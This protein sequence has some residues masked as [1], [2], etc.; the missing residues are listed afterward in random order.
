[1][2]PE[3]KTALL[4]WL[5]NKGLL[6]Q[7]YEA[8][9]ITPTVIKS[10]EARLKVHALIMQ[11]FKKSEACRRVANMLGCHPKHVYTYLR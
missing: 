6:S 3:K 1:M 9:I 4:I 2:S 7:L 8:G 5:K 11:G 10:V